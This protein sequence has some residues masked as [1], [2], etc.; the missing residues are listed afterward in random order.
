MDASLNVIG[1]PL[2]PC[3]RRPLTGWFRD[4]CCNTDASDR[5]SHT[6]CARVTADF[7]EV[8]REQGNDLVTPAPQHGFPGLKPGDSWCVCAGSWYAAFQIGRAC[9]VD[10]ERTHAVALRTVPLEALMLHAEG[11]AEA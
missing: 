10:L 8:L 7:L 2:K 1:T 3:S 6:V 11:G 5:G 9:P 4:G